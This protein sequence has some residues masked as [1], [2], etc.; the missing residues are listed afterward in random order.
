VI[1]LQIALGETNSRRGPGPQSFFK[2][3]SRGI[4]LSSAEVRHQSK[5]LLVNAKDPSRLRLK[6]YGAVFPTIELFL[7]QG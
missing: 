5:V 3:T 7:L 4:T 1:R 2:S 6:M